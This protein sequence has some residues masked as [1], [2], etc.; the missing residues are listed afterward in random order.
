MTTSILSASMPTRYQR[1]VR[2]LDQM[3][4]RIGEEVNT[5]VDGGEVS[6]R[7]LQVLGEDILGLG[8][9]VGDELVLVHLREAVDY[10]RVTPQQGNEEEL[11]ERLD[12]GAAL[13]EELAQKL[14]AWYA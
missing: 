10:V 6:A 13:L 4:I 5:V 8:K 11:T 9:L 1:L 12:M 14:R 7:D 2:A 3:S